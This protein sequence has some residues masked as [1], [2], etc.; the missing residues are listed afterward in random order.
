MRIVNVLLVVLLVTACN[1]TTS[2]FEATKTTESLLTQAREAPE[3]LYSEANKFYEQG[4]VQG[5]KSLLIKAI[6]VDDVHSK[7][8][9]G[10]IL[11]KEPKVMDVKRGFSLI[12]EAADDGLASAQFY[13]GSCLYDDGCGLLENKVLSAYYLTQALNNGEGGAQ[14]LLGFLDE[15]IGDTAIDEKTYAVELNRY[16]EQLN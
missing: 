13:L 4:D 2:K 9:L 3:Q 5:A 6:E 15:E 7:E 1:D 11:L 10:V 16:I 14:M 12:S 8:L